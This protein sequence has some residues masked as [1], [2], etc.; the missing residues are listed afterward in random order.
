MGYQIIT[1][2]CLPKSASNVENIN[3]CIIRHITSLEHCV[4]CKLSPAYSLYSL[5]WMIHVAGFVNQ[6]LFI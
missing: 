3:Y 5:I 4:S 6:P 1:V 2:S